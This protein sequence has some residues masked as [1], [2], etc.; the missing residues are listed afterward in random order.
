MSNFDDW[1]KRNSAKRPDISPATG[2]SN[3]AKR[4]AEENQLDWTTLVG[5]GQNGLIIEKDVLMAVAKRKT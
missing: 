4:I 1:M 3:L 5:T 2:I